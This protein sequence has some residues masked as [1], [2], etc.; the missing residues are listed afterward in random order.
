MAISHM[1][2]DTVSNSVDSNSIDLNHRA[3]A[4]IALGSNL[5][6]PVKQVLAA[7]Q[8]LH[9]IPKTTV[10]KQSSLYRTAP[11]GYSVA[12][13]QEIPDFI[14]AVA[15][16]NTTLTALDLLVALFEIENKFGRERPYPNAPRL[17][18]L[19]LLLYDKV[20]INTERLTLPHPRMFERGFVLLP[21]VEIAPNLQ[22]C[23]YGSIEDLAKNYQ[24]QGI[25]K[26]LPHEY[27]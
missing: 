13:L 2:S 10:L 1:D 23:I 27:I 11:I 19:D 5:N 14:N 6:Q 17:L 9:T 3:T 22:D 25:N 4:Y 18:D 20:V 15:E 26:L 24:N 16:V 7:L 12:Q 8:A 21:L